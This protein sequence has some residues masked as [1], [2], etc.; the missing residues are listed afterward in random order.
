MLSMAKRLKYGNQKAKCGI[1]TSSNR[2]RML[3]TK[4]TNR[5]TSFWME[6]NLWFDMGLV[7][8]LLLISD[9]LKLSG[10]EALG[11]LPV[12]TMYQVVHGEMEVEVAE[13]A[14]RNSELS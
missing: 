10:I 3:M 12:A 4:W 8:V 6:D 14:V 7:G 9:M 2:I 1:L 13:G 5:I 11:W